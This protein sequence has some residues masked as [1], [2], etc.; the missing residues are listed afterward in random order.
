M[1]RQ[2]VEAVLKDELEAFPELFLIDLS[3]TSE[4]DIY[5]Y[6]DGDQGVFLEVSSAGGIE[7]L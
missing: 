7:P 4:K 5:I 2:K 1:D 6:L 3:I